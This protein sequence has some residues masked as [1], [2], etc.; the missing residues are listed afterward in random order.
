MPPTRNRWGC[1]LQGV[2]DQAKNGDQV[3]WEEKFHAAN[4][5]AQACIQG[6]LLFFP[7]MFWRAGGERERE[8]FLSFFLSS[9]CTFPSG[10]HDVP[11]FCNVFPTCVPKHLTFIPICLGKMVSSFHLY[12]WA[13]REELYTLKMEPFVLRSLHSFSFLE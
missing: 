5:K 3:F 6:A 1:S 4:G 12:R 2:L 10:S 11:Q 8:I 9:Q 7:F 13:K